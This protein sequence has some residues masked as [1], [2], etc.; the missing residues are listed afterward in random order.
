MAKI[1]QD[2]ILGMVEIDKDNDVLE[3]GTSAGTVTLTPTRNTFA[4]VVDLITHLDGLLGATGDVLLSRVEAG[5]ATQDFLP[6][7]RLASGTMGTFTA[8]VIKDILFRTYTVSGGE[9]TAKVTPLYCWIPKFR[10]SD[11]NWF[12]VESGS[13][14]KGSI[15]V[16]GNLSGISYTARQTITR[17]WTFDDY[18]NVFYGGGDID[19]LRSFEGVINGARTNS[20]Q[21]Q[22]SGNIYCKGVYY[23]PSI[24]Y[25]LGTV[26]TLWYDGTPNDESG[27]VFCTADEPNTGDQSD[28]NHNKYFNVS[29]KLTTAT[30]PDWYA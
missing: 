30:A 11:G 2:A 10:S 26:S 8:G 25:V 17:E 7:I 9:A 13:A 29:L 21:Y 14:V 4:N 15:G 6:M 1:Y 12:K 20:L 24:T 19:G 28:Q 5:D 16:S 27:Y 18:Q 22:D 3:F 23:I